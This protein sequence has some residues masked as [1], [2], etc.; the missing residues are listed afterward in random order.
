VVALRLP[1][2]LVVDDEP[3]IRALLVRALEEAGYQVVAATDGLAGLKAA[4]S[5]GVVYDLVITNSYMP[6]MSGE[7]L[8]RRLRAMFPEQPILHLDDL[9]HPVGRNVETV[10]TLYKPF[11]IDALLETVARALLER[12]FQREA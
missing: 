10:P 1:R 9:S 3:T 4:K 11:S 7:E 12:P 5:A 8:I 6:Q 2:I